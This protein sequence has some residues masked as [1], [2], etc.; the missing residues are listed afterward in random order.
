[1]AGEH[2]GN[3]EFFDPILFNLA[4]DSQ[5][6]AELDDLFRGEI[7][8]GQGLK[9]RANYV[10]ASCHPEVNIRSVHDLANA[11]ATVSSRLGTA[12][13][14]RLTVKKGLSNQA[15]TFEGT[16]ANQGTENILEEGREGGDW[17]WLGHCILDATSAKFDFGGNEESAE[18][19]SAN[20]Q[21]GPLDSELVDS[22]ILTPR[23]APSPLSRSQLPRNLRNRR[24]HRPKFSLQQINSL[25][26][27][28]DCHRDYP[29]PDKEAKERLIRS[30]GLTEVQ[31]NRWF[32][33]RRT[34]QPMQSSPLETF[35]CGDGTSRV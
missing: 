30:T 8:D 27:W 1:M 4:D 22:D 17:G 19:S 35:S 10:N 31:I 26:E 15:D 29:Y 12:Y 32:T 3:P 24:R 7:G 5:F 20:L 33:N 11:A 25:E 18:P 23:L 9:N 28:L 16:N 2:F 21:N 6:S 34:R 14:E 13:G